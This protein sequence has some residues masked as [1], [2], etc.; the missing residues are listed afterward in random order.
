MQRCSL[1]CALS[2]IPFQRQIQI[3]TRLK[4]HP[5]VCFDILQQIGCWKSPKGPFFSIVRLLKLSVCLILGFLNRNSP[6]FSPILSQFSRRKFKNT[7]VYPNF[8]SYIRTMVSFTKDVE[9]RKQPLPFV[10]ARY[11]RTLDVISEVICDSL[12]RSREKKIA[13]ICHSRLHL[14]FR[15]DL[16]ASTPSRKLPGQ[17]LK[18]F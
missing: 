1:S 14:N 12:S 16:N 7:T 9:D 4:G 10:P 17:I 3:R 2:F 5:F 13:R 6:I 8:W 11:I 15:S 18:T